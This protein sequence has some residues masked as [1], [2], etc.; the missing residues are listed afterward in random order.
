MFLRYDRSE[1]AGHVVDDA[2]WVQ[3]QL[4]FGRAAIL[5]GLLTDEA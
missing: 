1:E 5:D 3:K 4:I 2:F